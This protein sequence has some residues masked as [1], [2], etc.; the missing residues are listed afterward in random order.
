MDIEAQNKDEDYD[1]RA[2]MKRIRS[3]SAI[4][5]SPELFEKVTSPGEIQLTIV[6]RPTEISSRRRLPPTIR[7]PDSAW[8]HGVFSITK[9]PNAQFRNL[10]SDILNDPHGLGRRNHANLRSVPTQ[11]SLPTNTLAVSS[12]SPVQSY[13]Y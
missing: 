9:Y 3:A 1:P 8:I 13:Y 4:T 5:I 12:S 6:I 11:L 10:N 2:D 7:Q